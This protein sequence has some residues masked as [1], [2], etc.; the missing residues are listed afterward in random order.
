MEEDEFEVSYTKKYIYYSLGI[1][2][3]MNLIDIFMSNAGPLVVS[4]VVEEFLISKGVPEKLAYAQYGA[5]MAFLPLAGLLAVMIRYW[6]D[7][8]GRKI[9][10][11]INI[12]GMTVGAL[13]IV[14]AQDF[15]VYVLGSLIGGMFLVADIQLLFINEQSPKE[16]RSRFV[17]WV[18]IIGLCGALMVPIFRGIFITPSDPN[19]RALF[20]LPLIAGIIVSLLVIFTFK[21]SSIYLTMKAKREANPETQTQKV[22]FFQAVKASTK[23]PN[24]K[25]IFLTFVIGFLGYMAGLSFRAYW[26]PFLSQN[27]TFQEVNIIYIIRYLISMPLGAAIGYINDKVGR[28][29]GMVATLIL[30]PVFLLLC[31]LAVQLQNIWLVGIFYGLFIYSLWLTL[32]TQMTMIDEQTPTQL[33]GTIDVVIVVVS[34]VFLVVTSIFFAI[35]VLWFPFEIVFLIAVIPGCLIAIPL[36]IK[37]LPETKA[38]DLTKVE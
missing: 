1:L 29:A 8:Y 3:L 15:W 32:S 33:R 11:T 28:K 10:L 19:W 18:R 24:F 36:A 38:T 14:I 26:E 27:F 34:V 20:L 23:L 37:Y 30:L 9:A 7:K 22:T 5:A 21:E 6:A 31:L 17:N 16:K 13:L 2:G 25:T 35:L 12:V 4:F